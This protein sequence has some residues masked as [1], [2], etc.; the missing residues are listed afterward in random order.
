MPMRASLV[1][2]RL[3]IF[4]FLF[5][6]RDGTQRL[7]SEHAIRLSRVKAI[8]ISRLSPHTL[9]GLPGII[10]CSWFHSL[11][12]LLSIY[13]MGLH[14]LTIYGPEGL[15]EYISTLQLFIFR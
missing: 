4:R 9:G 12:M 15:G 8:F 6:V 13:D 14:E 1:Y 5:N 11:G 3:F 2:L 7:C 10:I